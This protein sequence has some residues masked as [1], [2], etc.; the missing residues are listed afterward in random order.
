MGALYEG[1]C[2]PTKAEAQRQVCSGHNE[3]WGSTTT[4]YTSRCTTTAFSETATTFVACIQTNGGACTN[5]TLTY[6]VFAS[7][8]YDGGVN[9]ANYWLGAAL[10]LFVTLFGVKKLISLFSATDRGE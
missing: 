2:Y 4:V 8:D 9:L 5:R 1:V 7:C 6:P 10:L 3:F